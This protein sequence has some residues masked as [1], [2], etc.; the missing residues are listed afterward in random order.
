MRTTVETYLILMLLML[1]YSLSSEATTLTG[2]ADRED[3]TCEVST[4]SSLVCADSYNV[5]SNN[6]DLLYD[7][8][9]VWASHMELG[10]PLSET[11]SL[12]HLRIRRTFES[13]SFM[14][15]ISFILS[16]LRNSLVLDQSK[17]YYSDKDPHY[18]TFSS[19]YYIYTLRQI[20]I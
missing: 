13:T 4:S 17:L 20:L 2:M 14:R 12:S 19:E 9:S 10:K 16:Q 6:G 11:Y 8:K 1:I 18:A 3:A 7:T 5:D 15:G